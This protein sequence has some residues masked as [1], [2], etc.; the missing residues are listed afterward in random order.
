MC[1]FNHNPP[2]PQQ[3]HTVSMMFGLQTALQFMATGSF[4]VPR[5]V[6]VVLMP[7]CKRSLATFHRG[8]RGYGLVGV[9]NNLTKK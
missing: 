7:S 8:V 2:P 1:F 9:T 4:P 5:D 3:W 6:H